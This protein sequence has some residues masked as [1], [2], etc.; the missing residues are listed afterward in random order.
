[1]VDDGFP[2]K[3]NLGELVEEYPLK[4]FGGKLR[5]A[6]LFKVQEFRKIKFFAYKWK[7]FEIYENELSFI[8]PLLGKAAKILLT[9]ESFSTCI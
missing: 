5:D 1:M 9:S 6:Q 2:I 7:E 8:L 4:Y 3:N